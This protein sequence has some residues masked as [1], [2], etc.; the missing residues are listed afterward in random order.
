[1]KGGIQLGT[2]CRNSS[3]WGTQVGGIYCCLL[4]TSLSI[5]LA[6]ALGSTLS[7]I[8]SIAYSS[9]YRS[10]PFGFIEFSY[11]CFSFLIYPFLNFLFLSNPIIVLW[12]SR[13]PVVAY[14]VGVRQVEAHLPHHTWNCSATV[15]VIKESNI[16]PLPF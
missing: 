9:C 3:G 1:M 2:G 15:H 16:Q 10:L 5:T 12:L 6:L 8:S 4:R 11:Y 7:R 14:C 13:F